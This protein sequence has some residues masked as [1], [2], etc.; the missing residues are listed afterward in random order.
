MDGLIDFMEAPRRTTDASILRPASSFDVTVRRGRLIVRR[1]GPTDGRRR[2]SD[3]V[4]RPGAPPMVP[5]SPRDR[6]IDSSEA[7]LDIRN[8]L[9][10]VRD[11]VHNVPFSA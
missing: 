4:S 3:V 8:E 9:T 7:A 2:A 6:F 5:V 10:G 1:N 11:D